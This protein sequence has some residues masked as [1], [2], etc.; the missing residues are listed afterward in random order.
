[1]PRRTA[2][3]ASHPGATVSWLARRLALDTAEPPP[4]QAVLEIESMRPLNGE[5]LSFY[6]DEALSV[7]GVRLADIPFP[8]GTSVT[9]IVRDLELIAPKGDTVLTPGDHVYVFARTEERPLIQLMFGHPEA[10]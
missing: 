1:M 9:L 2:P 10:P 7:S 3:S 4:A 8:E 6:I 5:L